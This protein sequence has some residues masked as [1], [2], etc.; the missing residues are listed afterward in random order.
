[1]VRAWGSTPIMPL[2]EGNGHSVQLHYFFRMYDKGASDSIFENPECKSNYWIIASNDSGFQNTDNP[3]SLN[4]TSFSEYRLKNVDVSL[5]FANLA[6]SAVGETT[7]H[8]I[9]LDDDGAGH[10]W[11]IDSTPEAN[12]EFL[13]TSNPNEFIAKPGSEAAGKMDLLTVLLHEY[14]H[15]LGLDHDEAAHQ[16]MGSDASELRTKVRSEAELLGARPDHEVHLGF[17]RLRRILDEQEKPLAAYR[18]EE[19]A[20]MWQNFYGADPSYY[21]ARHRFV[22]KLAPGPDPDRCG[23]HLMRPRDCVSA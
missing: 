14:G 23:S 3:F 1:M 22:R 13:P 16:L 5:N 8:S 12:D 4:G 2:V 19:L 10:G 15:A 7:G 20:H 6:N 11:F 9:T 17:N 18:Q 21:V